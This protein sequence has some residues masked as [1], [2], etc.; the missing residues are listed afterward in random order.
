M[1]AAANTCPKQGEAFCCS[2]SGGKD[3]CLA[4]YRARANG[5]IPAYLLT[6]LVEDG[7]RTRSH[8]L[9]VAVV[10]QQA[11]SLGIPLAYAATSW[12]DYETSFIRLLREVR[13]Q[14]IQVGVFGDIDIDDHRAWE[15]KVCAAATLKA[16]LPLWKAE[17]RALLDEF[18]GLGFCATIVAVKANTLGP[19]FLG[20]RLSN[21]LTNQ[22]AEQGLD[23]SGE[24]GEYHTVVTDGPLF[25]HPL[26]LEPQDSI[27]RDGYWFLDLQIKSG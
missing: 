2:W 15:E 17:R 10:R 8:G 6:M 18:L 14:N 12:S 25:A 9:A 5:A 24:N 21:E 1:A 16:C 4:L 11:Q 3:S 27:L 20:R 13:A 19:E 22:F 7:Q 23:P 26:L